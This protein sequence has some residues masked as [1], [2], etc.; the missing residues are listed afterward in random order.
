MIESMLPD[1]ERSDTK[2]DLFAEN[3]CIVIGQKGEGNL[4][5]RTG[6]DQTSIFSEDN[7]M[8]SDD[9]TQGDMGEEIWSVGITQGKVIKGE[10]TKCSS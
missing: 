8:N 1:V 3:H 6:P 7:S 10:Y 9:M 2:S 5:K 4:S